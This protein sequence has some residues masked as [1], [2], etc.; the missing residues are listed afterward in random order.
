MFALGKVYAEGYSWLAE[1]DFGVLSSSVSQSWHVGCDAAAA[2]YWP[3]VQPGVLAVQAGTLRD[4]VASLGISTLCRWSH[5]T[6]VPSC[7]TWQ[8]HPRT[9]CRGE[10]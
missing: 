5:D 3:P 10:S 6:R 7:F 9:V 8:V 4:N 2:A 1:L